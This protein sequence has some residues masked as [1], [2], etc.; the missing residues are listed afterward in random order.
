EPQLRS[1]VVKRDDLEAKRALIP[2][3]M[4]GHTPPLQTPARVELDDFHHRVEIAGKGK[5]D[6]VADRRDVGGL[7][8]RR[9]PAREAVTLAD[10]GPHH[11]VRRVDI[12]HMMNR[13]HETSRTRVP[14]SLADIA[15]TRPVRE[16]QNGRAVLQG[17]TAP[18]GWAAE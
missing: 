1:S 14:L 5:G 2:W 16:P 8:L 3:P 12:Q 4:T 10:R 6:A 11:L 9:P 18:P 7:Q 15:E 13:L 17:A